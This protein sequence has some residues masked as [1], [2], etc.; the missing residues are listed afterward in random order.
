ML[1][2]RQLK[3]IILLI[4]L[5]AA[6]R[7]QQISSSDI[8]LG[9]TVS[10]LLVGETTLLLSVR[11]REGK[12]IQ[13]PGT[14]SLRGDMNHAGMIPVF[15]EAETSVDGTFTL[16]FEWTMAGSW[17]VEAN[18]R[19]DSGEVVTQRFNLEIMSEA[20]TSEMGSM[21]HSGMDHANMANMDHSEM[22]GA[23]ASGETSAAYI[24]IENRG[25]TDVVIT[26]ARSSAA[27][28]A[29][30]H[31]TV[32][33]DDIAR[34]EPVPMLTIPAGSAL[35]LRP[36]GMHIMLMGLTADL[37]SGTSIA[38][39]LLLASGEA[40]ELSVPIM[41]M[42]MDDETELQVGDLVFSQIWARPASAGSVSEMDP[43]DMR[44]DNDSSG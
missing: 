41:T 17:I 32:I 22:E 28:V 6:C 34:M 14:L 43:Q 26:S 3:I 21:D 30:F 37:E 13:D 42:Q 24:R 7:Q 33:E 35:H 11:D 8:E 16:P 18:L 25:E 5:T 9:L 20:G 39:E 31:E 15:A 27:A 4:V 2:A 1:L 12:S 36:G 19:L 10:D 40:I 23:A 38:L 29:E 44:M